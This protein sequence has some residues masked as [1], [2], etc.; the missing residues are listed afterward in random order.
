[1]AQSECHR[2]RFPDCDWMRR[3]PRQRLLSLP[4]GDHCLPLRHPALSTTIDDRLW[5]ESRLMNRFCK[6]ERHRIPLVRGAKA[7]LANVIL[8]FQNNPAQAVVPVAR[9]A[10]IGLQCVTVGNADATSLL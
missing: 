2:A 7:T 8:A 1:D 4:L 6:G 9:S 3:P 10:G 5:P